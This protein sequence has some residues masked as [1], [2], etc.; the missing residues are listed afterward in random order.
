M[1]HQSL[2]GSFMFKFADFT[3]QVCAEACSVAKCD[4]DS[5]AKSVSALVGPAPD[6]PD[7]LGSAHQM[8]DKV[9]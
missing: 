3:H 8:L 4:R 1:P 5:S 2:R 9:L 6:T 7:T